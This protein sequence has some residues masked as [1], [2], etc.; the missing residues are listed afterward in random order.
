MVDVVKIT[1]HQDF[2]LL[3]DILVNTVMVDV[4]EIMKHHGMMVDVVEITNHKVFVVGR[5]GQHYGWW[6]I[7]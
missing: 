2:L 5:I 3:L 7:E 6:T 4:M 1:N